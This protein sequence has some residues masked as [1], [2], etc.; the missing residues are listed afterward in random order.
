MKK[1]FKMAVMIVGAWLFTAGNSWASTVVYDQV[2]LFQAETIFTDSFE[3]FDAGSYMA[4]LTDFEFPEPMIES[5]MSV[6]S[7]TKLLG[8]LKAPG[9]FNFDAMPGKYFVTF[10]GFADVSAP[11]LGQYGIEI[12]SVEISQ[13]PVP[14][15]LWLFG[16]GLIGL[17]GVMR[18]NNC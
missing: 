6:V 11:Q 9:S 14:A 16:S 12:S 10:Y 15:A 2:E 5:G 17:V 18:R 8:S 13:V 7:A 3:I 4:T 1:A